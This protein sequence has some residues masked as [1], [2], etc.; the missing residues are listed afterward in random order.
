MM[1]YSPKL[2]ELVLAHRAAKSALD[3]YNDGFTYKLEIRSHGST[4]TTTCLNAHTAL[5]TA[6]KFNGDNGF[7][8][9]YTD[10]L[11]LLSEPSREGGDT[12]P[13]ASFEQ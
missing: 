4:R 1:T 10:N 3:S 12:L 7:C 9:I 5:L 2:Q 6:Q 8:D 11:E 13:L